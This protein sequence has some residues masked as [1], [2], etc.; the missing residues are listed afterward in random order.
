MAGREIKTKIKWD[1][2][3]IVS[4]G[5]DADSWTVQ[6]SVQL[7]GSWDVKALINLLTLYWFALKLD[8]STQHHAAFTVREFRAFLL[9]ILEQ[10]SFQCVPHVFLQANSLYFILSFLSSHYLLMKDKIHEEILV[11]FKNN[12]A[13]ITVRLP[14]VLI[15]L[16]LGDLSAELC[17][18]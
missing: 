17:P 7:G 12:Q 14:F 6:F 18:Y 2:S 8:K 16:V 11:S 15:G 5:F 3:N 1:W 13:C 9:T 10:Q 4:F